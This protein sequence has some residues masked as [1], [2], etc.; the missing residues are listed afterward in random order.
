MCGKIHNNLDVAGMGN[1]RKSWS[2]RTTYGVMEMKWY[3]D[4]LIRFASR[5]FTI[6]RTLVYYGSNQKDDI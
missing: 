5:N 6:K 1:R 3:I 4:E 2:H